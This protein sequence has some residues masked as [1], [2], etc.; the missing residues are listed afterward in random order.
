VTSPGSVLSGALQG[1]ERFAVTGATGW[2]GR[3]ALDLLDD[4][5]GPEVAARCVSAFASRPAKLTTSRGREVE[6]LPLSSLPEH[7]PR[8]THL[9]H[10][11][12]LTRDRLDD[13][14]LDAYVARNIAIT[15]TVLRAVERHQPVA[16]VAASSGAVYREDRTLVMDLTAE[17][18]GTLK[19]LDEILFTGACQTSGT[20]VVVPRIFNLIGRH[21]TKPG[22][23]A[24][25][26]LILD[27]L[28]GSDLHVTSPTPVV[29]AYADVQAVIAL[30]VW[31]ALRA[32]SCTFDTSG[33]ELEVGQL[34]R[35][36]AQAL[37]L[38]DPCVTRPEAV[39]DHPDR[40]VGD[41]HAWARLTR[42]S[43]IRP[44]PLPELIRETATTIEASRPPVSRHEAAATTKRTS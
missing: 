40:Y 16:L 6:V 30:S 44:R 41:H 17:P 10:F 18:Y 2:L 27:A 37:G 32:R 26:S 13:L 31:L 24:L 28:A 3:N 5:L 38:A 14:S 35:K 29:R 8:S 9:L 39:P 36:V 43:G 20:A 15:A 33:E 7:R 22:R 12:Y 23:Y 34:A 25:G 1:D 42:E 11:A 21:M 19:H 4:A